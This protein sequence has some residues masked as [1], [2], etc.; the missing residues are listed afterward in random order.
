MKTEFLWGSVGAPVHALHPSG[1]WLHSSHGREK[2]VGISMCIL[3]AFWEEILC[4][5]CMQERI[6]SSH[7][8]LFE[9]KRR[10][11]AQQYGG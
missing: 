9:L 4:F 7:A 10:A 3:A 1:Y 5:W 8:R 11:Q 6:W 2:A